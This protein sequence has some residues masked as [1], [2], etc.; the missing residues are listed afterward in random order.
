[1]P[2][3][4]NLKMKSLMTTLPIKD[5][6][7]SCQ[8][9]HGR[10]FFSFLV[11]KVVHKWNWLQEKRSVSTGIEGANEFDKEYLN[12]LTGLPAIFTYQDIEVATGGFNK[13]FGKGGF[14]TVYE[15]FLKDGIL[16]AIKCLV[17]WLTQ[18]QTNFCEEITTI[19][20]IN[21]S[22]L[23]R[24][25]GICVEGTHRILVYKFM[26]NGSLVRW[27]FDSIYETKGN[28]MLFCGL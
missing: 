3:K 5:R 27:L 7:N 18:G 15:G 6:A 25:H 24:L 19:S 21:H 22:N 20:S 26:A 16:V 11:A 17:N 2:T 28:L 23:L 12:N 4:T 8:I 13:E 1:M 14:N 10:L 9:I